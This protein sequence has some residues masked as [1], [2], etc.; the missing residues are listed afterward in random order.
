MA[1]LCSLPPPFFVLSPLLSLPVSG[2]MCEPPS[3]GSS[4]QHPG[5][6]H[7]RRSHLMPGTD[8]DLPCRLPFRVRAIQHLMRRT[9]QLRAWAT[10]TSAPRRHRI[11]KVTLVDTLF[12]LLDTSKLGALGT[13]ELLE[14]A[15]LTGSSDELQDC[16]AHLLDT[17]LL[18]G[19]QVSLQDDLHATIQT[20]RV[21]LGPPAH[22]EV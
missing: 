9:A 7:I 17:G 18:S 2:R 15:L 22:V 10:R 16:V 1:L 21:T 11:W 3:S 4:A 14:F 5:P 12:N 13:D 19:S 8:E 20:N 6:N